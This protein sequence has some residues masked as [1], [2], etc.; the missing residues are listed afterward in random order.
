MLTG[1]WHHIF[2]NI[3]VNIFRAKIKLVAYC[4]RNS[5]FFAR[6]FNSSF[7]HAVSDISFDLRARILVA[8]IVKSDS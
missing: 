2:F 5:A 1:F 7:Q 4:S 6:H 8:K 3:V